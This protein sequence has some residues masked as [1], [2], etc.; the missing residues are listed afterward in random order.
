MLKVVRF[1]L[2]ALF[3]I[4]SVSGADK[5]RVTTSFEPKELTLGRRGLLN[6]TVFGGKDTSAP[7]IPNVD[8]LVIQP[9]GTRQE[10]QMIDKD[11]SVSITYTFTVIPQRAGEYSLPSFEWN[12]S[13]KK[14]SVEP[15]TKL[16][17]SVQDPKS[18]EKAD[19]SIELM[20]SLKSEKAFVGQMVPVTLSLYTPLNLQGHIASM[21]KVEGKDFIS[22]EVQGSP[23]KIEVVNEVQKQKLAFETY[24]IPLKSGESE[25]QYKMSLIIQRPRS[26][27]NVFSNMMLNIPEE[28]EIISPSQTINVLTLPIH[29]KP[30]NFTGAIGEFT[31]EPLSVSQDQAQVGDPLTLK[32]VI[33][34]SGN[35]DRISPPILNSGENWKAY[36]PKSSFDKK[37]IF[38]FTG[39]KTFEYIIIPQ[40]SKITETP[41]LTFSFFNPETGRYSE[42]TLNPLPLKILAAP[43]SSTQPIYSPENLKTPSNSDETDLLPIK[44]EIK[45]SAT[46]LRPLMTK[47]YFT[48]SLFGISLILGITLV[49][50]KRQKLKHAQDAAY[51]K[52][53][54]TE[55]AIQT[56]LQ[57]VRKAHAKHD[58]KEFYNAAS[59]I[60]LE[61]VARH[62]LKSSHSLNHEDI[63]E[64]L[65][66]KG[67]P[68]VQISYVQTIF[69]MA[70]ILKFSGVPNEQKL[71]SE[72]LKD[73]ESLINELEKC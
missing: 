38:G 12:I 4:S 41:S 70:D 26:I 5:I 58:A 62:Y 21:S 28:I 23:P 48:P 63:I 56:N 18:E 44:L 19:E 65:K 14:Y 9:L 36:T 72:S 42:L 57:K 71:T 13:G 46:T 20:V 34:G 7:S 39:T 43:E 52:L 29:G 73:F 2:F 6:V 54:D 32:L 25:L 17:V 15:T 50:I 10:I 55:R 3:L 11:S 31:V 53:I 37:D 67:L 61:V 68:Q 1:F 64:F 69:H 16:K 22:S 45:K 27:G 30:E 66:E 33:K 49:L 59:I 60:V 24:I 40:N 35:M 47:P 51:L 8:G